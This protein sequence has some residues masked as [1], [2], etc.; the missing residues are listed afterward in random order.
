MRRLISL[1]LL[2]ALALPNAAAVAQTADATQGSLAQ[3][4]LYPGDV[5]RVQVYREQELNGEFLVDENGVVVLPLI[6]ERKVTG[7]PVGQLRNELV[8]AYRVH[9]RN[10]SI[11]IT[12][13]RRINVLG[14]VQKPG[15]YPIDPTVSL[16]GAIAT[17]GGATPTGNLSRI[18]ILRGDRVIRQRIGAAETL[19]D[20]DIRSGDQI[21]VDRRSWFD[22]NSTFLVSAVLSV[23]SI[24]TTIILS[25]DR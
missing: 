18:R 9:L 5:V 23:T 14:E 25:R 11:T 7:I 20:A 1:V 24:V 2:L 22:R 15:M 16:A 21:I 12:P 19:N 4:T 3:I 13:L 6:G 8:E 10:P 17:A